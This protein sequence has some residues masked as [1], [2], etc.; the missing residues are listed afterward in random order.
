MN[1]T[2][3]QKALKEFPLKRLSLFLAILAI[4]NGVYMLLELEKK[5]RLFVC[6]LMHAWV[7]PGKLYRRHVIAL[8]HARRFDLAPHPRT[9]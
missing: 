2:Q 3:K 6:V 4:N 1:K 8:A 7:T 9:N 5:S